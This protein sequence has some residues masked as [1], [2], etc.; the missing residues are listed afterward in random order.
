LSFLGLTS[1]YSSYDEDLNSED[2]YIEVRPKKD[3]TR[4]KIQ[5][6]YFI[7]SD[8]NDTKVILDHVREGNS[9]ILANIKPLRTK[10][11]TELKRSISKIRKT[12]EAVGGDIVGIEENLIII[13]PDFAVVSKEDFE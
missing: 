12:C 3:N 8:Y 2:E 7:I 6:K 10:D 5:I 13:Y 1:I 4:D 11:L 9:I